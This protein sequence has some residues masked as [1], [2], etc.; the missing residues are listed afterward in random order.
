MEIRLKATFFGCL[1]KTAIYFLVKKPLLIRPIFLGPIVAI[2]TVFR[3]TTLSV[4]KVQVSPGNSFQYKR[5]E[6]FQFCT[7]KINIYIII[8]CSWQ[9]R[10]HEQI[11][12][13]NLLVV[14]GH[15]EAFG[16]LR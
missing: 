7:W 11:W 2:L 16:T 8:N 9:V 1:A 10:D 12:V 4:S 5:T 6:N 14:D 15:I 3:C 13:T